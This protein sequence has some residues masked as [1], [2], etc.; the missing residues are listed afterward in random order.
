[1]RIFGL[2]ITRATTRK[3]VSSIGGERGWFNI[4]REGFTGAFQQHVEVDRPKD[5]LA[6]SAV[7]ACVTGIAGDIAKL[8]LRIVEE[9]DDGILKEI[10][11]T[12]PQ[13]A[14][15][16]RP[17]HFQ[18]P[19]QFIANWVI[20]KLI[21]GNTYALKRRDGRGVVV[22]LYLLDPQ[23]VT[24]LVTESGDIYYRLA[25]DNLAGSPDGITVPASEIIHD[26]MWPL[27]HPLVGVSP[28]Y[29]CAMSATMGNKIQGNSATFF[30]NLSAPSG[31]LTAPDKITDE[32]ATRLK[33]T[34][35][36]GFAGKNIGR[37]F[38]A[39]EGLEFKG[40]SM[41]AED[42]Q[43]I[44]QLKWTV[45]D[46][47]R[48]FHYPL[49]K[50]GGPVPNGA[51]I[52]SLNQGYYSECLQTLIEPMEAV[53]DYGLGLVPPRYVEAD[54]EGLLRMDQGAQA[55]VEEKL[56]KGIK[57]PNEAR[58]RFNLPAV[59]GGEAPYLQQQNFSLEALA[60]RDAQED[61]FK[62]AA[63]A[64]AAAPAAPNAAND[65]E[66]D[67]EATKLLIADIAKEC[68]PCE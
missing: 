43:L 13:A 10:P 49:Y 5:V 19:Y 21:W 51:S 60:K 63:P 62:T 66:M 8:R 29:A 67:L 35:E 31:M 23:R 28:I 36:E 26:L 9:S 52:E 42:A 20:S 65:D 53:L 24:P 33:K 18:T 44:E 14:V 57:S 3:A 68:L 64:P 37:V 6:F 11:R 54:L 38:V 1:M 45:E 4:L 34:F 46:V 47:G 16:R 58:R 32:T 7:F 17:N 48:A 25:A 50:L 59:K 2:E 61:P 27:W 22:A 15:L 56:I 40:M 55:E 39:G 41:A 12:A 30:G